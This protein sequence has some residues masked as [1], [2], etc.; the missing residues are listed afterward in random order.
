MTASAGPGLRLRRWAHVLRHSPLH[1]QWHAFRYKERAARDAATVARGA[2]LDVGCADGHLRRRLS[3]SVDYTGLD[4]PGTATDLYGT[5]PGVFGDAQRL[6]F[7]Q[8]SFDCVVLLD[9]LEHLPCPHLA[10]QE[11]ARVLRP[12]G[13]VLVHVPFAYPL[14]DRPFDYWRLSGHGLAALAERAGL[15][16]RVM[17]ARGHAGETAALLF[18]LTLAR[19]LLQASRRFRPALV[20]AGVL[21]P[22]VVIS[23]LLGWLLGR[24]LPADEFLPISYWALFE[25]QEGSRA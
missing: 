2:L 4:F 24:C 10:V 25:H 12:A 11:A 20:V 15:R 7:C 1:P 21:A 13:E 14:H 9:V 17:E 8:G 22:L 6:P 19:G 16:V 3:S 23:N 5:R 18:N